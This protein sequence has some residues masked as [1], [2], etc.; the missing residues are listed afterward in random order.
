MSR[1]K[2]SFI[3]GLIF[4]GFFL[5]G[6]FYGWMLSYAYTTVEDSPAGIVWVDHK[7]G[8]DGCDLILG[9]TDPDWD[10][11]KVAVEQAERLTCLDGH[12]IFVD[13]SVHPDDYFTDITPTICKVR[14]LEEAI[15]W[16]EC[17]FTS[18]GQQE[19]DEAVEGELREG[20]EELR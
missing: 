19:S 12:L 10:T 18:V 6:T 11:I 15:A 1:F 2:E 16:G 8:K 4:I 17:E 3:N 14:M 5:L 9:V 20:E 13:G 7:L